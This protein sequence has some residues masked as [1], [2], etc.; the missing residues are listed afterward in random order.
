M[1]AARWHAKGDVRIEDVPEPEIRAG[2]V[3]IDVAWCGI[4]GTD[5]HEFL[6]GPL[7]IPR[8]GHPHPLSGLEPPVILGHE[9]AGTVSAVG[10]GVDDLSIGDRVAVEP[11]T[12]CNEC[13]PCKAGNYNTC[14]KL[15][16]LG[17]GGGGGGLS[18]RVV[19]DRRWVHPV[20]DMPLDQA[21]MIEPLAVARRA[22]VRSDCS[23]GDVAVVG[24]A[25]PVGL[26]VAAVLRGIG[27]KTALLEVSA[28]R[29][30]VAERSG[31]ADWVLDPT[32]VDVVAEVMRL[33]GGRGADTAF[34]CAG[35]D[36]VLDTCLSVVKPG[37]VV[38]NVA[39]WGHRPPLDMELM[40]N[41]EIDLRGILAYRNDHPAT[42][43]LVRSGA[44][45]LTPFITSKI[46]L[47][48]LVARGIKRLIDD[49]G[50]AVKVLVR[51]GAGSETP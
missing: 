12:V 24:G 51:P 3:K 14:H 45:D 50:S 35:V 40:V 36:A 2:A 37:A 20:G 22:V 39:I 25:G 29:R 41:K 31:V 18:E 38:V 33:T 23:S 1:K 48:D 21:A 8:P 27:C 10:D 15:G 6:E 7:Y 13:P 16:I 30:A 49:A 28:E 5:V 9:F 46:E 4:C 17:L 42:I 11:L 32:A 47:D 19:V 34:E 26:L 44:I 43:D